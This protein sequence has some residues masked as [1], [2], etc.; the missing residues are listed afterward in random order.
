MVV[1]PLWLAVGVV[2]LV[3]RGRR[4]AG[5]ERRQLGWAV[6]AG[7][8]LALLLLASPAVSR[9]SPALQTWSFVAVVSVLPFVLLAGLVRFRLMDVDLYVARTLARGAVV[10]LVL[11]LYAFVADRAGDA[12]G[13]AAAALVV[14]AALTGMPLVRA[15]E[16]IVDRWL[17]GRPGPRPRAAAPPL[18]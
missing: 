15:L 6:G 16:R 2:L 5:E 3:A 8:L 10:V 17:S 14:L 13:V 1:G 11:L 4:A 9:I 7:G 12:E 18:R